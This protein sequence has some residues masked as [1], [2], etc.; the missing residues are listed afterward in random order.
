VVRV[1]IKDNINMKSLAPRLELALINIHKTK[2]DLWQAC[3]LSSGAASHFFSGE[4][5]Q[6]KG[7]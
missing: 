2:A 3:N 1:I 5:K 7:E 4:T 6:L